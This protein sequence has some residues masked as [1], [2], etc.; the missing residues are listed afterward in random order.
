MSPYGHGHNYDAYFGFNGPVDEVNGMMINVR[1]IKERIKKVLDQ[2]FDHKFI[3]SDVPDFSR[4]NPTVENLALQLLSE[5]KPLFAGDHAHPVF[6]HLEESPDSAATAY[7]DSSVERHWWID[8][9]AARRTYSPHLTDQEN[10]A[11]FGAASAVNGHGHH[12]RLRVTLAGK[13]DPVQGMIFQEMEALKILKDLHARF[14]HKN[15]STDVP[16]FQG[17]PNTTE[18]LADVIYKD[19]NRKLPLVRLRLDEN[20]NFFVQRYGSGETSMSVLSHFYAAHRLHSH[21]LTE[22]ENLK[23]FG[24][25]NNAN[26]HGHRYEVECTVTGPLDEYSGTVYDLGKLNR[27]LGS[28]LENW[29]YR[30]LDREIAAFK[31]APS[32]G[33]NIIR[34]L[35]K[36]LTQRMEPEVSRLRL[37][38]TRKNRFTLRGEK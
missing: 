8:F 27:V 6:C 14:D 1:V 36:A 2:R 22:D 5:V 9:S 30:H 31:E 37:W 38:E 3:N 23:L 7:A 21:Q 13:I 35:Y 28:L 19:L 29:N 20:P 17:I 18:M 24:I 15:L 34:I 33:E 12:Y 25:C 26:G 32:T 10:T 4:T 16:E 11:L